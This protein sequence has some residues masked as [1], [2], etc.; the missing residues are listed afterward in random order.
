MRVTNFLNHHILREFW[1][2]T[3][4][5]NE[6]LSATTS[7]AAASSAAARQDQPWI[8]AAIQPHL[9]ELQKHPE[10]RAEFA[11]FSRAKLL[12][13]DYNSAAAAYDAAV[14]FLK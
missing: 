5:R 6:T 9:D 3:S 7:A 8:I 12:Q 14:A 10:V 2:A 13:G 1:S 4:I 11:E